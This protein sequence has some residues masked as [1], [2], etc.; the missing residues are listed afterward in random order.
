[1]PVVWNFTSG[2]WQ[3]Q[4]LGTLG[5]SY[6]RARAVNN[7]GQVV[8]QASEPGGLLTP[9]IWLPM[10]AYGLSAGMN[11]LDPQLRSGDMFAINAQGQVAGEIYPAPAVWLPEPALGLPTGLSILDMSDLSGL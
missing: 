4:N 8:G 6:G 11:A 5:G 1:V 2:A 10:A 7:L 3:L 9:F